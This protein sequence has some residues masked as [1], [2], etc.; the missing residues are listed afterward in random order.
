[1]R[2]SCSSR[3][4]QTGTNC[5]DTPFIRVADLTIGCTLW[6]PRRHTVGGRGGVGDL[7]DA[8]HRPPASTS[9]A[10]VIVRLTG[11]RETTEVVSRPWRGLCTISR[12][13]T[14]GLTL[15]C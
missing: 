4:R 6:R 15:H 2:S 8:G 9:G 10:P 12:S 11:W 1:M 13:A 3:Q 5:S 7:C 14:L